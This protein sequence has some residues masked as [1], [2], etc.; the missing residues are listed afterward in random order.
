VWQVIEKARSR[1]SDSDTIIR[2]IHPR[3]SYRIWWIIPIFPSSVVYT[4]FQVD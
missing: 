1:S 4:C 3:Y 2:T